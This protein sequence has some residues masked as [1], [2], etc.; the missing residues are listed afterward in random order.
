[1]RNLF[2]LFL[3]PFAFFFLRFTNKAGLLGGGGG[4]EFTE[5]KMYLLIFS[6]NFV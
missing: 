3:F 2:I 5:H 1:V 6:T 4:G